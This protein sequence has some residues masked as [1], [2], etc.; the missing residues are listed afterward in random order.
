MFLRN[1]RNQCFQTLLLFE[2]MSLKEA[3]QAIKEWLDDIHI[4]E[5][6]FFSKLIFV[7]NGLKADRLIANIKDLE[8][9]FKGQSSGGEQMMANFMTNV[10]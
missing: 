6:Q 3:K 2:Q 7:D 9:S 1:A 5:N 4:I 8:K 10:I